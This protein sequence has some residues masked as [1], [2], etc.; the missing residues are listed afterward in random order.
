L[1]PRG[2]VE[3]VGHFMNAEIASMLLPGQHKK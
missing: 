2:N 1:L 3:H